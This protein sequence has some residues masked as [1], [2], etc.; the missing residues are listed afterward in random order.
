MRG[1]LQLPPGSHCAQHSLQA[2]ALGG[3]LLP[4]DAGRFSDPTEG[5]AA[6]ASQARDLAAPLPLNCPATRGRRCEGAAPPLKQD[7]PPLPPAR[8][9]A[10]LRLPP[11]EPPRAGEGD[12]ARS[13]LHASREA[14]A[15]RY[16]NEAP[17]RRRTDSSNRGRR[18]RRARHASCSP[19]LSATS[20]G[21]PSAAVE[22][23]P[24]RGCPET[25]P[26]RRPS[27]PRPSSCSPPPEPPAPRP[28]RPSGSELVE[29]EA[30][31]GERARGGLPDQAKGTPGPAFPQGSSAI[32]PMF[33]SDWAPLQGTA[34]KHPPH[35]SAP[36]RAH[37]P[38]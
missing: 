37:T 3:P 31:G 36:S 11:R 8:G 13:P 15:P 2:G 21:A 10:A 23:V 33:P 17:V 16:L 18:P 29:P 14:G 4:P 12:V 30:A 19:A 7:R 35:A 34:P 38:A 9:G 6:G 24:R 5:R 27:W 22:R 25:L 20:S 1:P 26:R 28:A 32:R